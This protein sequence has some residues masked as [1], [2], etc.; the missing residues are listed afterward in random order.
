MDMH[1]DQLRVLVAAF[2]PLSD[3]EWDEFAGLWKPFSAGRKEILTSAGEQEQYLY[4]VCE[5][6]QRIYTLDHTSREATLVFTY[7]P[8]FG[9]AVDSLILRQP[10]RY[11]Y[12]TLTPGVFL[13][14]G[15]EGLSALAAKHPSVSALI[16]KGL[17]QALAG[18]LERLSEVQ[19]LSSEERYRVLLK[20]SP[21]LL[22]LVPHKYIASYLGIDP[23]NF[24]KLMNKVRI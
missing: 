3:Q 13:R 18:T 11:Y 16:M 5:G 1:L 10:S 20:R 6:V 22:Q 12:E 15:Y 8:S 24:S 17:A 2:S 9:G 21:H 23:T 4:F 7:P 14:A 19:S